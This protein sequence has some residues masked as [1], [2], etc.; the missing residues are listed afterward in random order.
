MT[1][2]AG[3]IGMP[4]IQDKSR[5]EVVKRSLCKRIVRRHEQ[6]RSGNGDEKLQVKRLGIALDTH[7]ESVSDH[8]SDLTSSKESAE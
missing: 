1:P 6:Y 7:F 4:S 5:A 8:C 3:D 2:F